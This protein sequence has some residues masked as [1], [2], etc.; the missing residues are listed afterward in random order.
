MRLGYLVHL[1]LECVE[2]TVAAGAALYPQNVQSAPTRC[3]FLSSSLRILPSYSLVFGRTSVVLAFPAPRYLI[4]M[5]STRWPVLALVLLVQKVIA[6]ITMFNATDSFNAGDYGAF[7]NQTF[8]T[9]P[10]TAPL[11]NVKTWNKNATD[12][13]PYIMITGRYDSGN[14]L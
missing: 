13:T 5:Q 1:S 7:P 6:D 8:K 11:L 12:D 10:A 3:L 14:G 2:N 9:T 4:A